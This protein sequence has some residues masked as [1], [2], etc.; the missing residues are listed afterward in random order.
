VADVTSFVLAASTGS[1][2]FGQFIF[3]FLPLLLIWYFLVIRPQQ[4]Q[5]RK[6][7]QMLEN[8]KTGDKIITSGGIYGTIIRFKDPAVQ[9][10]VAHQVKI[11]V[12]RTAIQALQAEVNKKELPPSPSK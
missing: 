2:A 11:D 12:S 9:L 10:E 5:R 8:L 7:Q 6:T 4:N 1:A 3:L